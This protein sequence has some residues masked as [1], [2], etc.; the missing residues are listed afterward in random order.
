MKILVNICI[1]LLGIYITLKILNCSGNIT[2]CFSADDYLFVKG[3]LLLFIWIYPTYIA[4]K[5]IPKSRSGNG[6]RWFCFPISGILVM[7]YNEYGLTSSMF[8]NALMSGIVIV[9]VM[10]VIGYAIYNEKKGNT[11][12]DGMDSVG[13]DDNR[14]RSDSFR[15]E[16]GNPQA[17]YNLG[18]MHESGNGVPQDY[19]EAVDLFR[20]SAEQGHSD[21]QFNLG[22][23]YYHGTGVLQ[24]YVM[25]H[26]YWNISSV[27]G[28]KDAKHNRGVVEKKMTEPQLEKA[29]YLAR[30]WYEKRGG[31]LPSD[32]APQNIKG[33]EI[34]E[35]AVAQYNLG[36]KYDEGQEFIQ[37]YKEAVKWYRLS[38]EQGY[39]KAQ[40]NL[41]NKYYYGKGVIQ[42]YVMA[43][44]YWNIASVSGFKNAIK[45]RGI[46]EKMMTKP[47]LEKAKDLAREWM[48]KHQ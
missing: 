35:D 1:V 29:K 16:H 26:M 47:Q 30:E 28:H 34:I 25:A 19:K 41:G 37:D 33:Q 23:M 42:D 13:G 4:W 10:Y 9:F 22:Y 44:M 40:Y 43:H 20:K 2:Y 27:S 14:S 45:N 8:G 21:A 3:S 17:Q 11:V 24:D 6:F 18:C 32:S 31:M 15:T 39:T 48:E 7:S 36:V 12:S 5:K 38:A 46:V